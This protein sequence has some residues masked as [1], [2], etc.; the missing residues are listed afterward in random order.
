MLDALR[1]ARGVVR[2]LCIYYGDR[3]RGE[4]MDRLYARFVAPGDLVFDV[5]AHVGDRVGAFRR[6]NA[7]VVAFEP[8][9]ALARTLKLLYGRD[10]KVVIEPVALGSVSGTIELK[11][12]L[13]NPTISTASDDFVAAAKGALGWDDQTWSKC[14][15]VPITT[16][17]AAIAR[18]G[19]PSFIKIDVEGLEAEVLAGLSGPVAALSFEFT[20]IQRA[21][22]LA[23]LDR[24][25]TLGFQD[26]DTALGE[27]QRLVFGAWQSADT[28]RDWLTALPDSANSGDV[29]AVRGC[30]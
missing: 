27:S 8:Q 19:V 23:A 6:M 20:T 12:N 17:D 22:A 16:L 10:D 14:I 29:Y 9:P 26:F 13:E 24:C 25:V 4:A 21:V 11:L 7:R 30:R 28:I 3:N 2:S 1:T 15:R 5:G 18:H